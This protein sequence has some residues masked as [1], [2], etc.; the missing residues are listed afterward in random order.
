MI[1]PQ[2][3]DS[4]TKPVRAGQNKLKPMNS[5]PEDTSAEEFEGQLMEKSNYRSRTA[6]PKPDNHRSRMAEPKPDNHRSQMA[7][8]KLDNHRSRM[9]KS[10]QWPNQG[11]VIAEAK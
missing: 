2:I 3:E 8:P 5:P 4:S 9:A 10:A 6:E 11:Q 7:E 1:I